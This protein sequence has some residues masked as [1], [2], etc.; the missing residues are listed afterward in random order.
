[1]EA[2]NQVLINGAQRY[3]LA[4]SN[5]NGG[6]TKMEAYLKHGERMPILR[7]IAPFFLDDKL[8]KENKKLLDTLRPITSG[9]HTAVV[10]IPLSDALVSPANIG[11][12]LKKDSVFNPPVENILRVVEERRERFIL[13]LFKGG[14]WLFPISAEFL[15]MNRIRLTDTGRLFVVESGL[16]LIDEGAGCYRTE[17]DAPLQNL[18]VGSI[19]TK[20]HT[21]TGEHPLFFGEGGE[22]LNFY[23][24]FNSKEVKVSFACVG[25]DVY[26]YD[27]RLNVVFTSRPDVLFSV[28]VRKED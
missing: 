17:I 6:I 22:P 12:F 14:A 23:P 13:E 28:V 5:E 26:G 24:W 7:Q 25:S 20:F 4:E 21:N 27:E 9:T 10:R 16:K 8:W 11:D 18:G 19:R 15:D 3:T 2:R 1:M